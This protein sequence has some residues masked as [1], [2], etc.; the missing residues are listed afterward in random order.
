M[1]EH[2]NEYRGCR[3]HRYL[4]AGTAPSGARRLQPQTKGALTQ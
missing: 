4:V 2:E 1:N 3:L